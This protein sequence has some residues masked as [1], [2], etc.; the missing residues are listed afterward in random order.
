MRTVRMFLGN[1]ER[2]RVSWVR[3]MY[4][5][6]VS[7]RRRRSMYACLCACDERPYFVVRGFWAHCLCVV[8]GYAINLYPSRMVYEAC[9]YVNKN[10]C[11]SSC[12]FGSRILS[13]L[14]SIRATFSTF[15]P[16]SGQLTCQLC[17]WFS[18]HWFLYIII[19]VY[20][21]SMSSSSQ[22]FRHLCCL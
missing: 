7:C 16:L 4:S 14:K 17:A 12:G 13:V 9:L 10:A 6:I 22:L 19:V 15:V 11:N 18:V 8:R 3:K 1:G 20:V 21:W 5:T 2:Q